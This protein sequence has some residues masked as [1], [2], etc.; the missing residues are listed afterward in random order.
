MQDLRCHGSSICVNHQYDDLSSRQSDTTSQRQ[1]QIK[2]YGLHYAT[3]CDAILKS[4]A[5]SHGTVIP[6]VKQAIEQANAPDALVVRD[7]LET[8]KNIIVQPK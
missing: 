1:D 8:L 3:Q 7:Y 4:M 2:L 6:R 5:E